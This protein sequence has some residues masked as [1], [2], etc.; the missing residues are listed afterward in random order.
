MGNH[1][2]AR[3]LFTIANEA[4]ILFFRKQTLLENPFVFKRNVLQIVATGL[5]G[6]NGAILQDT[7]FVGFTFNRLLNA[8]FE[9]HDR[10]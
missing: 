10:L 4:V 8:L 9:K 5:F 7:P 3:N 6:R 2:N 1:P